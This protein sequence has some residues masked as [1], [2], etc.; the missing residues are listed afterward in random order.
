MQQQNTVLMFE[1]LLMKYNQ[2][3][4]IAMSQEI[5]M[6]LDRGQGSLDTSEM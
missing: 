6:F 4:Y 3:G 1:L 5:W 2:T